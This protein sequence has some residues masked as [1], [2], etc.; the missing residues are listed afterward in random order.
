MFF[1]K[2]CNVLKPYKRIQLDDLLFL[3]SKQYAFSWQKIKKKEF[4]HV[5]GKNQKIQPANSTNNKRD[6]HDMMDPTQTFLRHKKE[7][8]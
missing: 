3:L 8:K 2:K 4:K 5:K 6:V 7:H 1:S